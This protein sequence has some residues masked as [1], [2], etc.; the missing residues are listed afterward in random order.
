MGKDEEAIKALEHIAKV[1]GKPK[2]DKLQLL[3]GI[4]ASHKHK[5]EDEKFK[6]N[7][8]KKLESI[9]QN[10]KSLIDTREGLKRTIIVWILF[11]VVGLN[12]N[13][14]MNFTLYK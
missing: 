5:P 4:Q 9:L 2:P 1:N 6:S 13:N 10:V 8:L 7:F 12:Q 3:S 11:I 14:N